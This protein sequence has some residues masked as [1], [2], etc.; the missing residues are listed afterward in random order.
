MKIKIVSTILMAIIFFNAKSQIS[1]T[2]LAGDYKVINIG[3]NTYGDYT[4]S[5]ILLHEIYNGTL[6]NHN[7]AIGTITAMRGS[8]NSG[9]L[10]NMVNVTTS[11][12]YNGISGT[13]TSNDDN[14]TWALKTCI[15]NGK[16]YLAVD[17][18]YNP[19]YHNLGYYFN[20]WTF[21]TG[22]NMKCVPYLVNGAPVNTTLVSDIQDF[23]SNMIETHNVAGLNITGNV[24]IGTASPIGNLDVRGASFVGTPDFAIGSAGS[25]VQIDQGANSGNTYSRI[26]A[27]SNGGTAVNN[28]VLQ[29]SGGNVGIG[30]TSPS[31]KMHIFN[32]YDLSNTTGFKMFYQGTWGTASYASDFRFIDVSS[33]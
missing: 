25:M 9:N 23:S 10:L 33:T 8:A 18:P 27:F 5:L 14:A 13:I 26:R 31:A 15:Y 4:H 29:S 11:S 2:T 1:T 3:D 12:A 21:S 32:S 17:I 24:G 28:L 19:A 20:G 16:R 7:Y 22:E 6:I 30:T